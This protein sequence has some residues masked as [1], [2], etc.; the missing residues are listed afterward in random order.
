MKARSSLEHLSSAE[1][2]FSEPRTGIRKVARTTRVRKPV[3]E[4]RIGGKIKRTEH[5]ARE[6]K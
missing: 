3:E 4:R 6:M 2:Q 5:F 1:F